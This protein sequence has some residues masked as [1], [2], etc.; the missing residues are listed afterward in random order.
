MMDS[1]ALKIKLL[2]EVLSHLSSSRGKDLKALLDSD[3]KPAEGMP[4]E[5]NEMDAD[6]MPMPKK[7]SVVE[8]AL[9][10]APEVEAAGIKPKM[11]DEAA[12]GDHDEITDEELEELLRKVSG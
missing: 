10:E 3:G 6:G 8:D 12:I 7:D 2:D 11:G 9:A 4:G 5:G 1:N